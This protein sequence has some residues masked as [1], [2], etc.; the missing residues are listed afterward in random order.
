M[1][2]ANGVISS[3]LPA[4]TPCTTNSNYPGITGSAQSCLPAPL[5]DGGWGII[6]RTGDNNG[7]GSP[8]WSHNA[9]GQTDVIAYSSTNVGVKDGR[10]DCSDPNV[11]CA[12]DIYLVPYGSQ[13]NGLGGLGGNVKALMGASDPAYNEYYPSWA[14]DD[15][16]IAFNRVPAGT[17]MYNEAKAEVWVVPYNGSNGGTAVA[18]ASATTF[19]PPSCTNPFPDGVQNTWPKWAPNPVNGSGNPAPQ[20]DAAGNTYYWLTFSS[21]RSP[22]ATPDPTNNGKRKQQLYLSG[23]KV[24]S[25]GNIQTY[26]PIY[27]WNQNATVN[28]LIPAWGE[29]TIAAGTTTTM[30]QPPQ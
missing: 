14:P 11:Q 28:N 19:P 8:S 21:I 4:A 1:S 10:M 3:G 9:D 20:K 6:R 29:F 17:S 13:G 5:S 7:A 27:M 30:V 16:L 24:D 18:V 2:S 26:A 22:Q 15:Q 12:S 25:M 23:V